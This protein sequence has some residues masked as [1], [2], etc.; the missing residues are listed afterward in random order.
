M[1]LLRRQVFGLSQSTLH[2]YIDHGSFGRFRSLFWWLADTGGR[3]L[4]QLLF[5]LLL[6]FFEL[7]GNLHFAYLYLLT[8]KCVQSKVFAALV[9]ASGAQ[10][11]LQERVRQV[12]AELVRLTSDDFFDAQGGHH[13]VVTCPYRRQERVLTTLDERPE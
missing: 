11:T 4:Q 6:L 3:L 5:L 8:Q 13:I 12:H 7:L 9:G 2:D 1:S 10:Q